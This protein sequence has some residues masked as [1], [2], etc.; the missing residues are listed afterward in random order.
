MSNRSYGGV[1]LCLL[2]IIGGGVLLLHL[3]FNGLDTIVGIM[4]IAAGILI[5]VGK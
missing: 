3:T 4:A 1:L 5:L 2:L